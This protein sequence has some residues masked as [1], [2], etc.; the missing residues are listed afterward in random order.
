LTAHPPCWP[1]QRD[2]HNRFG[3]SRAL[4]GTRL[5]VILVVLNDVDDLGVI[6]FDF[7]DEGSIGGSSLDWVRSQVAVE[8]Y[9]GVPGR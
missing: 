6:F 3:Y 8:P 4:H 5:I 1:E 9:D 2:D 7:L